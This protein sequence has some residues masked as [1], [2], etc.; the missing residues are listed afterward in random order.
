VR[1]GRDVLWTGDI[2]TEHD[3]LILPSPWDCLKVGI[4]FRLKCM[5]VGIAVVWHPWSSPDEVLLS[6]GSD[7][8]G[9]QGSWK[10]LIRQESRHLGAC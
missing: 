9:S 6:I 4:T 7:V 1:A 2:A 8:E 3:G 10:G 5:E